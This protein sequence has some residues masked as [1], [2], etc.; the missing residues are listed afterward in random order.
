MEWTRSIGHRSDT[1]T[2]HASIYKNHRIFD[3]TNL[4]RFYYISNILDSSWLL[5]I[6][7]E[8]M[9]KFCAGEKV[10]YSIFNTKTCI[11]L[12]KGVSIQDFTN[13]IQDLSY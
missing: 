3:N 12:S 13:I 8:S 9:G 2:T 5:P 6:N 10:D 7:I 1:L 4:K 11:G